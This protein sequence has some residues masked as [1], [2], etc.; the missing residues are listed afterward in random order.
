MNRMATFHFTAVREGTQ[1][2]FSGNREATDKHALVEALRREGIIALTADTAVA[3]KLSISLNI[4]IPFF[5]RVGN[6]DK[7]IFARNLAAMIKAGLPL[8]RAI[9]I[10]ARQTKS[11]LLKEAI[12]QVSEGLRQGMPLNA[13]LARHPKI[14]SPLFIAMAR[15][16]EESGT[17]ADALQTAAIQMEK[18]YSLKKK[19]R[20]AMIY[21][22]IV[23]C[24]MMGVGVLMLMYVVP[25]LSATFS[26]LGSSL[27]LPT[28][29]V[30]GVS[31][32]VLGNGAL[33]AAGTVLLITGFIMAMRTER[34]RD[35]RDIVLLKIPVI[36]RIAIKANC[37]RTART[38]SALLRAGVSPL[39]ALDI[40][41]EAV[42][43][44]K[45]RGVI[46][47]ARQIIEKGKPLSQAFLDAA[48][49]YP[50]MFS[51]MAAVGEETGDVSGMLG[52]VADFYEEDVEEETKDISTIIEPILM[53]VI[54]AGV[55]F[56]AIA[57]IAP[58]YS[59]SSAV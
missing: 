50:P 7:I 53:V 30:L 59:L 41:R 31:N 34:G 1:E 42:P 37:A 24:V 39:V 5:T 4:N 16:G 10:L 18:S 35:L 32:F 48:S 38:L 8:S 15:A 43:N 44:V 27:P 55:G 23:L 14:F 3:R 12:N 51:E 29:I 11:K 17:L 2:V 9:G 6:A 13:A 22:M 45:F 49:I 47:E 40:T 21:P 20:G 19:I 28:L 56:F 26:S 25:Q 46:T 52:R 58:I 33:I 57:M 54:G 36:G